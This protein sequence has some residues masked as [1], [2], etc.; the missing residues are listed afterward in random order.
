MIDRQRVAVRRRVL[1]PGESTP[2]HVDPCHRHT[3]V[4]RGERL[5]I[6]FRDGTAPFEVAVHPG[7]AAWDAPTDLVHRA[8]NVGRTPYEEVVMFFLDA[9]GWDPQPSVNT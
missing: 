5:R 1:M 6:E 3:V 2:W 7:M 8:V 9:P 4:V